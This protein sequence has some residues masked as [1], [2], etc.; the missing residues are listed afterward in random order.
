M[1]AVALDARI[2]DRI[3]LHAA[4][5]VKAPAV[6]VAAERNLAGERRALDAG[7]RTQLFQRAG[8]E[9]HTTASP[10][11]RPSRPGRTAATRSDRRSKPGLA[12]VSAATVRSISPAPASSTSASTRSATT[13][14]DARARSRRRRCRAS[15]WQAC[16]C[17]PAAARRATPEPARRSALVSIDDDGGERQDAGVDGDLLGARQRHGREGRQRP[18]RRPSRAAR[19]PAAPPA[20]EHHA[21]GEQ[22]PDDPARPAPSTARSASSR[23]RVT[24]RA[25]SRFAT[26]AHAISSTNPT[27][28][29]ST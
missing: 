1:I 16:C 11:R 24:E 6:A 5:D 17:T 19:R 13:R 14:T 7:N 29:S 22:L 9:R 23:C 21:L 10:R 26:F 12:R 8:S 18:A 15:R 25:S 2:V 20:L 3:R 27:A 28:P 4:L